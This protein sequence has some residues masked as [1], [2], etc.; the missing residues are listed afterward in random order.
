MHL[1]DFRFKQHSTTRLDNRV[2]ETLNV[3]NRW[4]KNTLYW[5]F[6]GAVCYHSFKGMSK[7]WMWR[8]GFRN[9]IMRLHQ[10]AQILVGIATGLY[11]IP[12]VIKNP[13]DKTSTDEETTPR[14]RDDV[15]IRFNRRTS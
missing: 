5:M 11:C 12:L 7:A 6:V 15:I 4:S 13:Y 3:H 14:N 2:L 10:L 8:L 1:L 9:E